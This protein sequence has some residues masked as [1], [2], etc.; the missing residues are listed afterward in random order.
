MGESDALL[1]EL[2]GDFYLEFRTHFECEQLYVPFV[3]GKV[4]VD[5]EQWVEVKRA[6]INV[7]TDKNG[8]S[9]WFNGLNGLF[10]TAYLSKLGLIQLV[11]RQF[12]WNALRQFL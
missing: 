12:S 11:S 10:R 8:F 4:T 3:D 5:Q 1:E 2:H 9:T 7:K 6:Y